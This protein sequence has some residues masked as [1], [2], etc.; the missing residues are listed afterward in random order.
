MELFLGVDQPLLP[1]HV[2]PPPS[3]P[4]EK[5]GQYPKEGIM[6]DARLPVDRF[7]VYAEE[8]AGAAPTAITVKK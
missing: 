8:G 3:P 7:L 2:T 5:A 1:I 4:K 6:E